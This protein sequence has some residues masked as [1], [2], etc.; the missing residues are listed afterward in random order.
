MNPLKPN[1]KLSKERK[2]YSQDKKRVNL[3]TIKKGRDISCMECK[4]CNRLMDDCDG[5][6]DS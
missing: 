5:D 6:E 2:L 4:D 3:K 1:K